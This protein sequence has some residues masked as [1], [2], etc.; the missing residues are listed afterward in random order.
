MLRNKIAFLLTP[1]GS[2]RI[3]GRDVLW[4]GLDWGDCAGHT[5]LCPLWGDC[6]PGMTFL[7]WLLGSRMKVVMESS[8]SLIG[9]P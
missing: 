8:S 5:W 6:G 1:K 7:L 3:E 4:L 2:W 9:L